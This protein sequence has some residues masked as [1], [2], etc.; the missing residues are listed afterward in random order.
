MTRIDAHQNL[1]RSVPALVLG[2]T[3]FL[4]RWV[5]RALCESGAVVHLGVRDPERMA[6]LLDPYAIEGTIHE[7]DMCCP[8]QIMALIASVHPAITFNLAGY[9]VDRSERDEEQAFQINDRL[10]GVLVDAIAEVPDAS[11]SGQ[12]LVHVGSALEYGRAPGNLAESTRPEPTTLYGRSKLAGTRRLAQGCAAHNVCGLTARL[13]T[14]YGPGEHEGRLLPSLLDAAGHTETVP[15]SLG[16]QK[17]DFAYVEDIAD[18]LVRL[19]SAQTEPGDVVNLATGR[20]LTV[21]AF[22]ETTATVLGISRSRL[23]FGAVPIRAEEMNHDPVCVDRLRELTDWL[24][25][26]D[27]EA[28]IRRTAEFAS[29]REKP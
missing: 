7:V 25:S 19:G 15:L 10:L 4:G 13:F 14:V 6:P 27:L 3:G 12:R 17:R 16:S 5:A 20:L 26:C 8:E 2:A 9:G 28:G 24:P 22:I 11:W 29:R 18:G 21:R 1:Y 23:A